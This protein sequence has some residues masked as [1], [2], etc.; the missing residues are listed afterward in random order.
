MGA[1]ANDSE[2]TA[3]VSFTRTKQMRHFPS[4]LKEKSHWVSLPEIKSMGRKH[5]VRNESPRSALDANDSH[6]VRLFVFE[7]S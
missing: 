3:S 2:S 6:S 5:T 4:S 1:T 7:Q